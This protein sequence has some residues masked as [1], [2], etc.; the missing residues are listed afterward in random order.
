M[1][2]V[3]NGI[4]EN[5]AALRRE[6]SAAGH[7]Y[8]S[9][10]DTEAIAHLVEECYSGDLV[11]AVHKAYQRLDGHFAFAVAHRDSPGVL[12][13][14]RRGCPLVVGVGDGEMFMASA[15]P[16]FLAETR[17]VQHVFDD[18]IVVARTDGAT[19]LSGDGTPIEREVQEVEWDEDAAEKQG[20]ETF[21]LKEIWEQPDAIAETIG[22]RLYHGKLQLDGLNLSEEQIRGLQRV[23]FLACGTSYHAGL[24]GRY[25][26]EEWARIP[27]ESDIASEWRYRHA[28]IDSN[29]LVIAIAQ[30]G[31]TIDTLAAMKEARARGAHVLAVTNVMGSQMT[32][33]CDSVL[34]TRAGLEIGVAASKTFTAQL[35]LLYL[36]ALRLG[37]IRGTIEPERAETLLAQVR[38]LP[39]LVQA[40]LERGA[41]V[42]PIADR[43]AG[44]EFFL[45]LGRNIGL[46]I[47][48][49]GA[50]KLK[51]ISYISTDAYAAG[52]MKHGPIALLD[53]YD[54]R[55]RDRDRRARVREG[56][57]EHRGGARP[58]RPCDRDRDRGQRAHRAR[59]PSTSSTS[60]APSPSCRRCW[61]C[62]RC[63]SSPTR[64]PPAAASTSTS[65]ATWRRPSPSSSGARRRRSSL[66]VRALARLL[67]SALAKRFSASRCGDVSTGVTCPNSCSTARTTRRHP[68]RP[69]RL[70]VD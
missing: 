37:I 57:L 58:R 41:L 17:R 20:F 25:L 35:T 19:F 8:H 34:Y 44:N 50:L 36:L 49:E 62:C 52:E 47:A 67:L 23:V 14:A 53:D 39:D 70:P 68:G 16:A 24:V 43:F 61:P 21:M 69:R 54:A 42:E 7:T 64:S 10:T 46:P 38:A 13:A 48:L 27:S 2:V 30:S 26:L 66:G 12:V 56:R 6:L 31:E 29:T 1:T 65:R 33:E 28:V 4:I 55:G 11:E 32:R 40:T 15:I 22:E 5:Y 63:S 9:D 59:W 3:H 51:E 45:Y 60:R 18:E